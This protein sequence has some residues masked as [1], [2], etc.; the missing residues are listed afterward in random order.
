MPPRE[1][2]K[3]THA[4]GIQ[5]NAIVHLYGDPKHKGRVEQF[6]EN[7]IETYRSDANVDWSD[8]SK[9]S[10][11]VGRNGQCDLKFTVA[12]K[13]PMYYEQHL[14]IAAVENLQKGARVVRGPGWDDDNDCD[15]GLGYL[16]TVTHVGD[17]RGKENITAQEESVK[18]KQKK[19][20]S[21]LN[22]V[23]LKLDVKVQWDNG[24]IEDYSLSSNC[25]RLFDNG[26]SGVYHEG[27]V[28]G[29]CLMP[30]EYICGIR[31]K[32][33]TC[34]D[35]DLCNICYMSDE[36]DLGHMFQRIVTAN[37]RDNMPT[38]REHPRTAVK[39]QSYG[40]FKDAT[41]VEVDP[42][43]DVSIA[44]EKTGTVQDICDCMVD[45]GRSE[46]EVMWFKD[47]S[48]SSHRIL[49]LKYLSGGAFFYY[50]DHL[51]A[52]GRGKC[53]ILLSNDEMF[54]IKKEKE[55]Y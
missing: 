33:N 45:T 37:V 7:A 9:G 51:P 35:F 44:E 54:L 40:I 43:K 15:G 26:P 48:K 6:L 50:Y 39:T 53:L 42:E 32:C 18:N 12:A 36:H 52:L 4:L 49:D 31:W 2:Q 38:P 55:I 28:C 47:R 30:E 29:C 3:F 24:N 21:K 13:G 20:M 10:Y 25:L 5:P 1:N 22:M 14:P 27:Y 8:N 34:H 17:I 19:R 16:G 11:R 46:V 23:T 41:V